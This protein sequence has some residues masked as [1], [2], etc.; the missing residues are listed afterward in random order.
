MLKPLI[1]G[2]KGDDPVR[3]RTVRDEVLGPVEYERIAVAAIGRAHR[4]DIRPGAWF[5][6]RKGAEAK[7]LD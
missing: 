7:L 1:T 4:G 3:H 5:C 2:G 6:Q